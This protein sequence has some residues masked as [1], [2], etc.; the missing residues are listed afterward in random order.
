MI[1]KENVENTVKDLVTDFLCYDRKEDESL[2]RGEIEDAIYYKELSIEEI[3][4]WFSIEL[5][6]QYHDIHD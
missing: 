4:N 3:V 1:D 5:Q 2:G 6:K